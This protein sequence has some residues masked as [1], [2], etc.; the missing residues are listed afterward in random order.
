MSDNTS[1]MNTEQAATTPTPEAEGGQSSERMFT[2]TQVN[3]IVQD[4][5]AR[6]REKL[7]DGSEYKD[8]YEAMKKELESVKAEQARAAKEAAVRAYYES[9]SVTGQALEIAMRGSG[10]EI[11]A[12]E[13]GEDG[14]VKDFSSIDGLIG[15]VFSSLVSTGGPTAGKMRVLMGFPLGGSNVH[16][17]DAIAD[18]FKPKI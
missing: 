11:A 6:E 8:Q 16:S 13:L 4:R 10:E 18:A 15:G 12:L 2:Q 14:K 5:L 9:K 1:T 17:D 3:A 7:A